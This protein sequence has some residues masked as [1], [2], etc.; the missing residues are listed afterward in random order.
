MR[1]SRNFKLSE[2]LRSGTAERHGI[3]MTPTPLVLHNIQTLVTSV[4]QPLR[5]DVGS[6]IFISSGFRP[7]ELNRLI[8]GSEN[9]AHLTGSAAD[10][11][12]AEL[13]PYEAC[14]RIGQLQ[15]PF[16]Q[17]IHEFGRWTHVG[18]GGKLRHENLTAFRVD[19]RTQ[20]K[21]GIHRVD[22]GWLA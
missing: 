16:D 13:T 17:N 21:F 1:L 3:D 2:F 6:P 14:L 20:Y 7:D 19:G 12:I 5:D 9:S 10:F 15:L 22:M 8:R 11:V 18:I 4:M